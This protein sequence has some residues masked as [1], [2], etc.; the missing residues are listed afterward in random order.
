MAPY[1]G[2][3]GQVQIRRLAIQRFRG[4]ESLE[5]QPKS[6]NVLVGAN[7]AGKSSILEALDLALHPVIGRQRPAPTELDYY[8]RNVAAGF[9]IEVVLGDLSTELLAEAADGLEGWRSETGEVVSEVDGEGVEP[10]IRLRVRGTDDLEVIHEWAKPEIAGMRFGPRLRSNFGWVFDG[11]AREPSRQLAFYQGGLLDRVFSGVDM[12]PALTMLREALSKGADGLNADASVAGVLTTLAQDL[13][14]LGLVPSGA[15][16]LEAGSVSNREL[17]QTLRLAMPGPGSEAIAIARSG[18]GAQRLVLLAILLRLA[19]GEGHRPIIGGFEEPEE[20][21]EPLRQL[22]AARMLRAIADA[23]GQVFLSTHSPDI[24]RAFDTEDIVLVERAGPVKVRRL[25]LSSAG[26]HGYERRLDLPLVRGLFLRYPIVVEGVSDRAVFATF[27]DALAGDGKLPWA[28]RL[29]LE[30]ISAEGITEMPMVIQILSEMGK[31]PVAWVEMDRP[32]QGERVIKGRA[33]ALI[34][35]PADPRR[36]TLE[37]ALAESVPITALT[38]A[39]TALA[40]DRGDDWNVQRNDLVQ[41]SN[42]CVT[43]QADRE[44]LK[45]TDSLGEALA[46]P[47]Q[48]EAR[49]LVARCLAATK[50]PAPFEIK[51]GRSARILAEVIVAEAGVPGPFERAFLDLAKWIDAGA[52]A[53]IRID[54]A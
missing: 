47:P 48:A 11:R 9:E 28:E 22:Q 13:D 52:S 32:E 34:V 8:D 39:M 4:I 5:L 33:S 23:G 38:A 16:D 37:R 50:L 42:D 25:E 45:R 18:R 6:R 21:V 43:D 19:K 15:P 51:G 7:N 3:G 41:R 1:S 53:N 46:I 20:A 35:Y 27:W 40:D 30:P 54:M 44:A 49:L 14:A 10:C 29:G 24:V 31:S 2:K 17:L 26:R 12:E 36:D